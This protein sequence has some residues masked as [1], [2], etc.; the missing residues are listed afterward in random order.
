MS[1]NY[2]ILYIGYFYRKTYDCTLHTAGC[3]TRLH[4][5]KGIT[6]T[7]MSSLGV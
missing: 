5:A 7:H 3:P 6:L 2:G 4:A 1:F